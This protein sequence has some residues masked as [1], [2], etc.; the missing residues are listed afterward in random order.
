MNLTIHKR[1]ELKEGGRLVLLYSEGGVGKTT[2]F[3]LTAPEPQLG[4]LCEE[5]S[6]T[7]VVKEAE[8][9]KG[10]KI[11]FD[12]VNVDTMDNLIEFLATGQKEMTPYRSI[13]LDGVSSLMNL[14]LFGEILDEAFDSL[15]DS[16]KS[17]KPIAMRS[18]MSPEGYGALGREMLRIIPLLGR[19]SKTGRLVVLTSL[20]QEAPKWNRALR[21]APAF[22]GKFFSDNYQGE[23]DLIGLVEK[24]WVQTSAD[25][26]TPIIAYPPW[27]SFE[28][29][30]DDFVCKWSGISPRQGLKKWPLNLAKIVM[31][32]E[33]EEKG[34]PAAST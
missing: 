23:V 22:A 8:R 7:P 28:S 34:G 33:I 14:K 3:I 31:S 10:R 9:V 11:H 32:P 26:P 1:E 5:R 17:D 25:D 29:P 20:L 16:K 13:L 12:T 2:S 21:A 6:I 24:R 15:P 18:K 4:I 30:A 27:V 19:I